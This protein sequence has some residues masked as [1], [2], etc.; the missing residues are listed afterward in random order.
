MNRFLFMPL[1][2]IIT[3]IS[4]K[5][6]DKETDTLH[7]VE[8]SVD[9]Q[10]H[11]VGID[12]SE[13]R[14]CWKFFSDSR[15]KFQT[16]YRIL[17][18]ADP[19]LLA[20]NEAD[21]WDSG[22][23]E[24]KGSLNVEYG[25][26]PLKSFTKYYWKL[27]VWDEKG[28]PSGWSDPGEFETS[29]LF[30]DEWEALWIGD[31]REVPE[32]AEDFYEIIP[33][34]MFRKN[35]Q[36]DGRVTDA[37]LYISGLGY[38]EAYL[39]GEK[40]GD[41]VLDPGWTNYGRE[42][43]Y[44]TYD[45]TSQISEGENALGVLLGN[46]W[47]NPLPLGLFRKFNLRK[48]L[49]IG[50]PKLI[51]HLRI[52]LVDGKILEIF[53]DESWKTRESFILKNNVYLG[54]VQD[55]R[56]KS[57]A[58]K[59]AGFDDS[60]W[61]QV[62]RETSPGGI[63]RSQMVPPIKITANLQP[64]G[65]TEPEPGVFVYDLGQNF[66]GWINFKLNEPANSTVDF[67]Y[68]ELLN[69]D[70]TVNGMTAVAGHIKE[71]WNLSGGPGAPK[72]AFQVDQYITSG[73][74]DD[75]FQQYFTFHAF[76]YV[77]ISGLSGPPEL[78]DLQGLRL[79]AALEDAGDFSCSAGFINDLQEMVEWTFLSNVFSVQSDCPGREKFGY[80]G[81]IVTSA[82][83]FI[84]NYDM[85]NFY[86]KAVSDFGNDVRP[87][88]GMPECGPYNGIDTKGFG[89]G[90]GP[91]GWQLAFPFVQK[92]LYVFYGDQRIIED[93]YELTKGMIEFLRSQAKD[94]LIYHGIS[95]HVS[96]DPKPEALTSGAFYYHH[97]KLLAEFAGILGKS[98]DAETYN[99]LAVA[100]K[101]AFIQEYLEEGTGKFDTLTTQITQVFALWYG[102]I[103]ENERDAAFDILADK[104]MNTHQGH[105]STGIFGTKMLF[106]VLRE[107]N[108]DD[109]VY[110]ILNQ[111]DYPGYRF[112]M[113]NNATTLWETWEFPEQNSWNHPMFGSVS[114]WFYRSLLG[115][116]PKSDAVGFDRIYIRPYV[117]GK[118]TSADGT[119]KSLRGNVSC[120]WR[121]D[122]HLL[123]MEINIAPNIDA[124]IHIP[125][126]DLENITFEDGS[127]S[128]SLKPELLEYAGGYAVYHAGNGKF[129][130]KSRL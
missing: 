102:L 58:W 12:S 76:R 20:I 9:Y 118:I 23:M 55:G 10:R 110:T 121:V 80:G 41:H 46:G 13:P 91:I 27:M 64:V 129:K 71:I 60:S 11:A 127:G 40:I 77:Q 72:T 3:L 97:V 73:R 43:L 36:V 117:A 93:N 15:N 68:G 92:Q 88:G 83:A 26:S 125:A 94:N 99:E 21:A 65:L 50:Q 128:E 30:Q 78:Q 89:E 32:A 74:E 109:I 18:S 66:A 124:D 70:G 48:Y 31:G 25:G 106:D 49:T 98:D 14:F 105:L 53:S 126:P 5:C 51:A 1:L 37:R 4:T 86:R 84:F 114:E 103:P 6:H 45:V 42:I 108:R 101:N 34:P 96:V 130:I 39:N 90:T 81:D 112:M 33:A 61:N 111:P 16:A 2:L 62:V 22:R 123:E 44:A 19:A 104:I 115:I 8:L 79:S 100:I 107:N 57:E 69:E 17:V 67:L 47:Y 56:L 38:Y 7:P 35:F 28:E 119:Y 82:E 122:D 63:L 87:N 95:D 59:K 75:E 24:D 85:A 29:I 113:A 54:E 120:A 116:N 52:E